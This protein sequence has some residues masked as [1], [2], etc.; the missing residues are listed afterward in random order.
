[1]KFHMDCS[2]ESLWNSTWI[3][4]SNSLEIP[5]NPYGMH[6]SMDFPSGFHSGYGMKKWLGCQPK[7]SPYGFHGM[8]LESTHSIWNIAGSV[9][10]SYHD[11][12]AHLL[13][14]SSPGYRLAETQKWK[15]HQACSMICLWAGPRSLAQ[16]LFFFW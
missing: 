4:N 11:S 15:W 2:M 5:W 13:I 12:L 7:N 14:S 10:T 8:G 6:H 16:T 1:M 9:K 3:C